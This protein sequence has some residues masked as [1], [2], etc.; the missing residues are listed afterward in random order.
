MWDSGE[1]IWN[2]FNKMAYDLRMVAGQNV[3]HSCTE[4]LP[5]FMTRKLSLL[6]RCRALCLLIT[7]MFVLLKLLHSQLAKEGAPVFVTLY[8]Y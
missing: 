8:G 4:C 2:C 7:P 1:G 5:I 3:S 6:F